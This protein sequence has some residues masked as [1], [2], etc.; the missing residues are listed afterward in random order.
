MKYGLS[1]LLFIIQFGLFSQ[2]VENE[3]EKSNDSLSPQETEILNE[4]FSESDPDFDFQNKRIAYVAG[5]TG[6]I[7]LTKDEFFKKYMDPIV[8]DEKRNVCNLIILTE[9]EKIESGG[10]DAVI[11]TPAKLF[12]DKDRNEMI[13]MLKIN[14]R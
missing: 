9:S 10:Y 6:N 4:I 12:T 2:N 11:L 5:T 13:K 3:K 1:I 8:D 14:A 7:I